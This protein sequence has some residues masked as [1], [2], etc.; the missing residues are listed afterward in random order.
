MSRVDLI[1]L[2]HEMNLRVASCNEFNV[3]DRGHR[4]RGFQQKNED[5]QKDLAD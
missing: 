2:L 4:L 3:A 5:V 1:R